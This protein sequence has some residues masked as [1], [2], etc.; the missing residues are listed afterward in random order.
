LAYPGGWIFAFGFIGADRSD[1]FGSG[2][3]RGLMPGTETVAQ[4][5]NLILSLALITLLF[6]MTFKFLLDANIA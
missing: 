6:G 1:H 5:L 2:L 4:L 3:D